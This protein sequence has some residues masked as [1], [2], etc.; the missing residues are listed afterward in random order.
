MIHVRRRF[1]RLW[2]GAALIALITTLPGTVGC[3][4]SPTGP[5]PVQQ[6]PPP[7]PPP[8]PPAPPPTLTR[9]RYL[10]FGDS[11]TEGV[12]TTATNWRFVLTAGRSE[13]YPFKLQQLLSARYTTQA[14][15][16]LNGGRAGEQ[17]ADAL[18]RLQS[19]LNEARDTEVVLLLEGI[20]DLNAFGEGRIPATVDAMK[21]L[22]REVKRRGMVPMVATMVPLNPSG[23]RASAAGWIQ[24][25]NRDLVR[26]AQ[27][28]GVMVVDLYSQF[29]VTLQGPDGLHPTEQGYLRM[30]EIFLAAIRAAFEQPATAGSLAR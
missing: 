28:E 21:Q 6:Q 22:M 26:T 4:G 5:D 8:P 29:D 13:S 20:N 11:L 14:P 9:L 3:G 17:A 2:P 25:Y 1:L 16:V 19:V 7:P 10:A 24:D 15:I 27:V 23:R 18:P 12:V 30:A